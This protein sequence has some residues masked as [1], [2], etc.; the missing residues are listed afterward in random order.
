MHPKMSCT[1]RTPEASRRAVSSSGMG[2]WA[3]VA[4]KEQDAYLWGE[5]SGFIGQGWWKHLRIA[6]MY[7]G[8]DISQVRRT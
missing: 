2:A 3:L 4:L 1:R 7:P 5:S 8:I 6:S